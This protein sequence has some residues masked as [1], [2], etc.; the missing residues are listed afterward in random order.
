MSNENEKNT[1]FKLLAIRPLIGCDA[2]FRKNLEEGAIFKFYQDYQFFDKTNK[3]ILFNEGNLSEDI[4]YI[5][6]PKEICDLY[7]TEKLNINI[8]AVVGKNGSGK[9]S[10]IELFF[11]FVFSE[12]V[13]N[14]LMNLDMEISEA[15]ERIKLFETKIIDFHTINSIITNNELQENERFDDLKSTFSELLD[16]EVKVK[17]E[18]DFIAALRESK[19]IANTKNIKVELFFELDGKVFCF[20]NENNQQNSSFEKVK[21]N[22]ENISKLFYSIA[23]NYSLYGLN[24]SIIGKWVERLFHKND[25]YLTPIVINPMRC[26]GNIDINSE[27]HLN[28]SR[29]FA[30]ILDEKTVQKKILKDKEIEEIIFKQSEISTKEKDVFYNLV[31]NQLIK[32]KVSFRN[33]RTDF[34]ILNYLK[35]TESDSQLNLTGLN[36]ENINEYVS[37]KLFKI[38]SKYKEYDMFLKTK[39]LHEKVITNF[40]AFIY[41]INKD[42]SHKT[43]KLRQIL[44]VVRFNILNNA[45]KEDLRYLGKIDI[46]KDYNWVNNAFRISFVDFAKILNY[47]IQKNN[48]DFRDILDY[49]PNSFF[50][51]EFRFKGESSFHSLSSGEQQFLNSIN[52][53]IY[54]VLNL[55]SISENYTSINIVFDEI[56]L[57]FHVDFQ[58]K[59]INELTRSLHNVRLNRI[60]CVNILF[61]THSPFILSDIPSSNILRLEMNDNGKAIPSK[62]NYE[63]FGANIHDLLANDFFLEDGFMGE[64]AKNK[65]NKIVDE[66]NDRIK[67]KKEI[68][69]DRFIEIE[70]IIQLIGEPILKNS[71]NGLFI[72]ANPER[73]YDFLKKQIDQLNK[74]MDKKS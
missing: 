57:Y 26:N 1:G 48:L 34:Q 19:E 18:K 4:C 56:E 27:N 73:K 69:E 14:G 46:N 15:N 7:S 52:T 36:L 62:D 64:F 3:E 12:S 71:L 13:K 70:K 74:L 65:I 6:P 50:Q 49:I 37:K 11:A 22:K 29:I 31:S 60:K 30:N 41:K 54:H 61:S 53:V 23:L 44:N 43:L 2:N 28:Q 35:I 33:E 63:T 47:Q 21:L 16:L 51:T 55:D 40:D 24:S 5:T 17:D 42:K 25:G 38:A 67:N 58:R 59:F 20:G 10:L 8:S 45:N 66:L 68:S 39:S 72:E 9:S 32:S